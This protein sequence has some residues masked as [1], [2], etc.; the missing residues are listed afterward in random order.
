[1][2]LPTPKLPVTPPVRSAAVNLS[3]PENAKTDTGFD[4]LKQKVWSWFHPKKQGVSVY[5]PNVTP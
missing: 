5:A 4:N 1:M 2:S 3:A